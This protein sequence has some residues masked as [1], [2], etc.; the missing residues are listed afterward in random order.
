MSKGQEFMQDLLY[1]NVL[2]PDDGYEVD[3]AIGTTFS[4]TME[5]LI[6]VPLAF[7]GMGDTKKPSEQTAMY[8]MEGI[9]RG[10]DKFILF[11]NKGFIHV[12]ANSQPLY[13]MMEKS[14]FELSFS[15]CPLANFH[16]TSFS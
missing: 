6:S 7:S 12:P 11:C 9:R 14:V 13:S 1:M 10:C 16:P 15:S 5:G 8:L 3:F 2:Q 4:L